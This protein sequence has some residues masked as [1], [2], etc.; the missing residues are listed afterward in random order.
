MARIIEPTTDAEWEI[1]Y[2]LR[3]RILR[4]P[5]GQPRG[6]EFDESDARSINRMMEDGG[7]ALAVSRLHFNSE[8]EAQIRY[9]AV[10]TRHQGKG[11]GREMLEHMEHI[12][13]S[14]GA[15]TVV[16]EARDNAVG[17]YE[18]CGYTVKAPSYLLFGTIQHYTMEKI[19]L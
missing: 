2:E 8:H 13:A 5:W 1:Y 4:A 3:Y 16:L 15:N 14:M 6:S 12:S 7:E 18:R 11:F 10:D 17:F 9:M 19:V